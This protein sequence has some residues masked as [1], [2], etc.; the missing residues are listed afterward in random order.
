MN[1]SSYIASFAMLIAKRELAYTDRTA[2]EIAYELG[3]EDYTYF[4]R[5]FRKQTGM[6]PRAFRQK[7]LE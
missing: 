2:Q 5:Q 1:A 6:S 3:Y 4:S 7:Y